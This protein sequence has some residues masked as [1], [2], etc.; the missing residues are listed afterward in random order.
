MTSGCSSANTS[1]SI[2]KAQHCARL[3]AARRAQTGASSLNSPLPN[4]PK[5]MPPLLP[6]PLT[7]GWAGSAGTHK[8]SQTMAACALH[9]HPASMA[10]CADQCPSPS[11]C[12]TQHTLSTMCGC[13]PCEPR[14][15]VLHSVNEHQ[16]S[17]PPP[18]HITTPA[19]AVLP[20]LPCTCTTRLQTQPVP[21]SSLL[22]NVCDGELC[23]EDEQHLKVQHYGSPGAGG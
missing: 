21:C 23:H 9:T 18:S 6:A 7:H 13:T 4:C 22:H 10:R 17:P 12:L 15:S 5:E 8:P 20:L 16:T 2:P 19:V 11:H 3:T 1:D 14:P